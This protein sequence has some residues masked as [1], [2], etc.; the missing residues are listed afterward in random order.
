M[1]NKKNL[2]WKKN[3]FSRIPVSD[4]LQ[5]MLISG[6]YRVVHQDTG[7]IMEEACALPIR[8]RWRGKGEY[9]NRVK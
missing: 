2:Q 9:K 3:V 1:Q 8:C 4:Y 6:R 5:W 7:T